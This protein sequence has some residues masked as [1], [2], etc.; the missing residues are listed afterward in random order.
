M[1]ILQVHNFYKQR[2]GEDSVFAAE[3]DV[4]VQRGHTV[5]QYCAHNDEIKEMSRVAAAVKTIWNRD[6]YR[7]VR[8]V[9]REH[10]PDLLH[11]HN[12]FPLISPAVY[13]A[14][15]DA[16][17]PVIQTLHNYR[18]LCPKAIFFRDGHIC[19][20]C[21]G[22]VPLPAILHGCYRGS[23]TASA[24]VVA[25]LTAHR[26]AG[27]WRRKVN[28]YIA[29]TEFAKAKFVQG[30]LDPDHIAVKP[31]FLACDP[32]I[33]A[34][35]GGY[36]LFAGRL[37]GEKGLGLLLDAWQQV[38]RSFRLKI[39]GDGDLR[40]LVEDRARQLP[41]V[42][43]LGN[44]DHCHILELAKNAAVQ[45]VP[46]E[47]YEGLPMTVVE[48]FAC[49]TPV[50][51]ST[52]ASMDEL[53]TDGVNGSRFQNGSSKDLAAS[54]IRTMGNEQ[55]L[56]NMRKQARKKYEMAYTPQRNY[57]MLM[58]IYRAAIS[59]RTPE[60]QDDT[61]LAEITGKSENTF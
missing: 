54:I 13:Y 51:T 24:T 26:A 41:N 55:L 25:L 46:S 1:R 23:K 39:A 28:T 10:A 50:I 47:W 15:A 57:A 42:Q 38:P 53:V 8:A 18:L 33:G 60:F 61:P 2:G 27:T 29:L 59:T 48:A 12:T 36:A 3:H 5:V 20:D 58:K 52:L 32:G 16:G 31:N 14:A 6:T 43:L 35:A 21:L 22:S 37:S 34:G 44:C 7:Q 45:I 40:S 49:G 9:I 19:E 56:M 30:G 4:L 11:A 17:V